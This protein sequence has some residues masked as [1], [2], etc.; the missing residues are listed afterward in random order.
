MSKCKICET[1]IPDGEQTCIWESRHGATFISF[2]CPACTEQLERD[3]AVRDMTTELT[4]YTKTPEQR[5]DD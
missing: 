1:E 3:G 4:D 5:A 2:A